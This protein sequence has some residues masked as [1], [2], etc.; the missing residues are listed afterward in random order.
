[1]TN[2]V[3]IPFPVLVVTAAD[4]TTFAWIICLIE[5]NKPYHFVK[6]SEFCVVGK[7]I[8]GINKNEKC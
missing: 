2:P 1:M 7:I 8:Q 3:C 4:S 5:N 6:I